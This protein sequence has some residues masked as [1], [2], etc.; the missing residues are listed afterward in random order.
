MDIR[1]RLN[2]KDLKYQIIALMTKYTQHEAEPKSH[3]SYKTQSPRRR[4]QAIVSVLNYNNNLLGFL[5][6]AKVSGAKDSKE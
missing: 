3:L 1:H 5:S 4:L 6:L 2:S